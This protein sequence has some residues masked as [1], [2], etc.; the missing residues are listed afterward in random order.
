M[1]KAKI[2]GLNDVLKKIEQY[3]KALAEGV[4]LELTEAAVNI[5]NKARVAAPKGNSG[6][7]AAS[8]GSDVSRKYNKSV[9][10]SAPYSAYVEFGTGAK[11][12]KGP[13]QF[14]PSMKAYARE[15]YIS[16]KGKLPAMPYL[17]PAYTAEV[18]ELRKRLKRLFFK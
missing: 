18:I 1:F 14:T 15:F 2:E 5:A 9:F 11:V 13:F 12:F 4:D 7:L 16:G 10:A 8:I 3:D 17:F 6:Q